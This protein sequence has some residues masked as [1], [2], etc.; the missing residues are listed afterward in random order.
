[1]ILLSLPLGAI[2]AFP[3][4]LITGRELGLPAIWGSPRPFRC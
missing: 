4:L 2:G 3:A 1:V